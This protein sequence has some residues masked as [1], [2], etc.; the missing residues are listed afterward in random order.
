MKTI[1]S[2]SINIQ[3]VPEIYRLLKEGEEVHDLKKLKTD[4]LLV[5]WINYHLGKLGKQEEEVKNLGKDL[6]NSRALIYVMTRLDTS[7]T[8]DALAIEDEV[9]RA[10]KM[11]E[12]SKQM[13]V[14]H[15]ISGKDFTIANEDLNRIFVSLL[16]NTKHGLEEL[17]EDEIKA[18]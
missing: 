2:K 8:T 13:G 3:D 6:K 16:F 17:T 9:E 7:L 4:E 12:N 15:V 5:R 1:A 10:E 14:P 18:A 11:I